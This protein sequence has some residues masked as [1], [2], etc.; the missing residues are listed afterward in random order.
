[1]SYY[2]TYSQAEGDFLGIGKALKSVYRAI[3][4]GIRAG[5]SAVMP[6]VGAVGR[7]VLGAAKKVG[8]T[9]ARHPVMSAAGAAGAL[10]VAAGAHHMGYAS[11]RAARGTRGDGTR[12]RRMNVTNPRA[13]RRAI[14]RANGFAK[15]AMR[16]IRFTHPHKKGRF[17]GFKKRRKA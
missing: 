13:L 12:H 6:G 10:A 9:V 14:R 5:I 4:P 17:G 7:E 3:E 1:M 15:L 16:T 11:G 2:R 8:G